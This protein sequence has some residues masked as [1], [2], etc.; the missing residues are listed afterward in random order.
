MVVLLDNYDSFTYN[1]YQY[2]A[3]L[4][5]AIEV[6][7]ND[8]VSV[9]EIAAMEPAG[10][11]LSPGPGR[12]E[13]AGIMEDLIRAT[14]GT[15]PILGVCLGHQAIGQVHGA[16]IGYAPSLMHGKT[17]EVTHDGS[18]LRDQRGNVA[19]FR[20]VQDRTY[21]ESVEGF[22]LNED[23]DE[24]D[25][26]K[27][28]R[29]EHVLFDGNDTT[30]T[31]VKIIPLTGNNVLQDSTSPTADFDGKA[32]ADPMFQLV[33]SPAGGTSLVEIKIVYADLQ[34]E[35]PYT[36]TVTVQFELSKDL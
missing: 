28:G 17:S 19:M 13:N 22:D 15:I 16:T 18:T 33:S 26:F 5:A 7:R 27:V 10:I 21:S 36:R 9:Q 2:L 24:S 11:V 34:S 3:E 6:F 31:P 25:T 23:D 20:F 1:L 14:A 4:G 12:P 32:G 30:Q 8:Q 35:P 29:I